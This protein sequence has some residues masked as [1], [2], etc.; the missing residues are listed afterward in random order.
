LRDRVKDIELFANYFLKK[1]SQELNKKIKGFSPEVLTIFK[2]YTWPGNLREINNIVKR[3][4]LLTD[5]EEVHVNSLPHEISFYDKFTF[6]S[7]RLNGNSP[8][9]EN[10]NELKSVAHNAECEKIME[11]L[12]KVNYNKSKAAK[13]LDIDRKTLYNKLKLFKLL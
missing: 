13:I 12:K 6:N 4:V 3:V 7:E 5:G 1:A 10:K 2:N 11:I 9:L 8:I